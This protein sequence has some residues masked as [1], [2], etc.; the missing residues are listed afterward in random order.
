[1]QCDY[2]ISD[3]DVEEIYDNTSYNLESTIH[4]SCDEVNSKYISLNITTNSNELTTSPIKREFFNEKLL[5]NKAGTVGKV[6]EHI[7]FFIKE[8]YRQEGIAKAIHENE[9]VIY[10]RNDFKQI[11]LTAVGDGVL[12]WRK[13]YYKYK[14]STQ[15]KKI[16]DN[17]WIYLTKVHRLNIEQIESKFKNKS[18]KDIS[19]KY[20]LAPSN[21]K[22]SFLKWLQ[23]R[24][25]SIGIEMYK[26]IT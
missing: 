9:L 20:F 25:S 13:L 19:S 6:A 17:L 24:P 12:V 15:E 22:D 7:H 4:K 1:M 5:F 10:T 14:D 3:N 23:K 16:L 8:E 2:I 21:G 18:L 11:Q 26:D